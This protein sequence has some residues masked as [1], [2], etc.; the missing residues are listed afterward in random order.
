MDGVVKVKMLHKGGESLP[1]A[2][3]TYSTQYH[4]EVGIRCIHGS[5]PWKTVKSPMARRVVRMN[6]PGRCK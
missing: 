4:C 1:G 2:I 5:N 6:F 3:V